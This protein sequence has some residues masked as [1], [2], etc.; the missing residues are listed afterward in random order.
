MPGVISGTA[1]RVLPGSRGQQSRF[2]LNGKKPTGT[3]QQQEGQLPGRARL[4]VWL[5]NIK[6]T[7][8]NEGKEGTEGW[9]MCGPATLGPKQRGHQDSDEINGC[10]MST[11]T[12]SN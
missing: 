5:Q 12:R 9:I 2:V 8:T 1:H 10:I 11:T 4:R 3:S 7:S 6:E